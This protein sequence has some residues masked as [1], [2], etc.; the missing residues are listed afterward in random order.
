MKGEFMLR[1]TFAGLVAALVAAPAGLQAQTPLL[2]R[3]LAEE[4]KRELL[5]IPEYTLFDWIK[6][7]LQPGY[8]VTLRGQATSKTK[9]A[10]L[11]HIQQLPGADNLLDEIEIL[12]NGYDDVRLRFRLFSALFGAD[13]AL[14]RYATRATPPIHIVVNNGHI[15]LKGEVELMAESRMAAMKARGVRGVR[16]VKNELRI[17]PAHSARPAAYAARQNM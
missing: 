9:T 4:I 7:E 2:Q 5:L 8:G 3:T 11:A 10:V 15:I 16:S 13:S 6:A 12:P 17:A 1:R 14:L